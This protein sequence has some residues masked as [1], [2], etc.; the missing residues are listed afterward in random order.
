MKSQ[1]HTLA[2]AFIRFSAV[3]VLVA[4]FAVS[5]A[6]IV[7]A[8]SMTLVVENTAATYMELKAKV[9][10]LETLLAALK[11]GDS[12]VVAPTFAMGLDSNVAM[13]AGTVL[14]TPNADLM[15]LCGPM[16]KGTIDWGD[17][18]SES[19]HGLGCSGD[20]HS[21]MMYHAYTERG[22]YIITVTD[23]EGRDET[24]VIAAGTASEETTELLEVTQ[25]HAVVTSAGV[26]LATTEVCADD[27]LAAVITWGDGARDTVAC[28]ETAY[29]F[30]HTYAAP[31]TYK[32]L[33]RS[34]DGEV[35]QELV[36][37]AE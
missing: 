18:F 23:T 20:V 15:E 1:P 33:V 36:V 10:F 34:A 2:A 26:L 29:E 21:F 13:I 31:G 37:I 11:A 6:S 30:E 3:L 5:Q 16:T 9:A 8:D 4:G 28:G 14:R 32:V 12:P 22:S 25:V 7:K 24:K 19:L 17:G 27:A 35:A